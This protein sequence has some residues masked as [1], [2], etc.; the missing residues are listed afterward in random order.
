MAS[1]IRVDYTSGYTLYAVIRN[2]TSQVWYAAG[3]AFESW[4]A[5]SHTTDDYDIP[6]TDASGDQYEGDFDTNIP[7]GVYWIQ[8]RRQ[9]GSSPDRANDPIVWSNPSYNWQGTGAAAAAPGVLSSTELTFCNKVLGHLGEDTITASDTATKAYIQCEL[10]LDDALNE[11][12]GG[13]PWNRAKRRAILIE[14]T[15]DKPLFGY[16]YAYTKPTDALRI[17]KP[18]DWKYEYRVEEGSAG[19]EVVVSNEGGLPDAWATSTYYQV[20]MVVRNG[21]DD[22]VYNCL[23]AHTAGDLDDEPGVGA[24]EST[25]WNSNGDDLYVLDVEYIQKLTVDELPWYLQTPAELM[26][27]T[28]IATA[29]KDDGG[30]KKDSLLKE[31]HGTSLPLARF[32]NGQERT[33]LQFETSYWLDARTSDV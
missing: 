33:Q 7:N 8:V 2:S 24:V 25:Y 22:T 13:H 10:Y 3:S 23:V 30:K 14:A 18:L 32:Y 29:V 19:N 26:L 27:A 6:L 16:D 1:E 20:G 12:V 28:K 21:D 4:G 31:L 15:S 17:Y 5:S 9:I 11:L